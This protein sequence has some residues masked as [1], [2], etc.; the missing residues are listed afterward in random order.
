MP[1]ASSL[2][3]ASG[4]SRIVAS[5][6]GHLPALPQHA[7]HELLILHLRV[8]PHQRLRPRQ[9]DES[10][11][12]A[13]Q[14]EARAVRAVA[15]GDPQSADRLRPQ[16]FEARLH[17]RPLLRRHLDV[18][19][20]VVM[21]AHL[22]EQFGDKFGR[23]LAPTGHQVHEVEPG[24]HAVPLR[25]VAAEGV[26]AGL[27]AGDEGVRLAHLGAEVLEADGGLVDGDAV[28]LAEAPRHAGRR[29][30]LYDWAAQA[31][32]LQQVVDEE[33]ERLELV[34]EPPRAVD[35]AQPV[36]VA[37]RR[38]A[39]LRAVA[40]NSLPQWGEGAGDGLRVMHAWE[41]RITGGP[42]LPD[43]RAAAGEEAAEVG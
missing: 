34:H 21:R 28:E 31:A 27:L 38:Q 15:A 16:P 9:A 32:H 13:V 33:R 20:V 37:V 25:Q 26:A 18:D 1:P 39:D 36:G 24:E 35:D 23:V 19:A 2:A 7:G 29:N 3:R 22:L 8:Y 17:P 40:A 10:P 11:A 43:P 42:Q 5:G 14:Q 4:L 12:A 30:G 41:Q 6:T